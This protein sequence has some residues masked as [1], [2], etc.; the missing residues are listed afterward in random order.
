[1]LNLAESS[2]DLEH[3]ENAFYPGALAKYPEADLAATGLPPSTTGCFEEGAAHEG[4]SSL[5]LYI[6][7][8][9]VDKPGLFSC[10]IAFL[11]KALDS[12]PPRRART[13]YP[14]PAPPPSPLSQMLEGVGV[15]AR[16]CC[17]PRRVTRAG[18]RARSTSGLFDVALGLDSVYSLAAQFIIF[19]PSSNPALLVKVF[20][21][22]AAPK[23]KV[24]KYV[25]FSFRTHASV[26]FRYIVIY[27]Y[28]IS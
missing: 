21:A 5:Q 12:R 19:C 10:H 23:S 17:R 3:L 7:E 16:P 24:H 1:M 2:S 22:T 13:T 4:S 14:T 9:F 6:G 11:V 26:S 18:W 20:P 27:Y 28:F 25:L 15:S 8:E